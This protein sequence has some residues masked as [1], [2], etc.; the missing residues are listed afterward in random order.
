MSAITN[1]KNP[2]DTYVGGVRNA[3]RVCLLT[4]VLTIG[5]VAVTTMLGVLGSTYYPWALFGTIGGGGAMVTVALLTYYQRKSMIHH[6]PSLMW[7]LNKC[8][9][10]WETGKKFLA[11][12]SEKERRAFNNHLVQ[13]E[14]VTSGALQQTALFELSRLRESEE[15][16]EIPDLIHS[17]V[18]DFP[19]LVRLLNNLDKDWE[20]GRGVLRL[21]TDGERTE[22]FT[23][24]EKQTT[25]ASVHLQ[26]FLAIEAYNAQAD[27]EEPSIDVTTLFNK[28]P[29]L[30]EDEE[31]TT[32]MLNGLKTVTKVAAFYFE[33]KLHMLLIE[34]CG[35]IFDRYLDTM[36]KC[37]PEV[38][39]ALNEELLLIP[40]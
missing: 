28:L 30:E 3:R 29:A 13:Q 8:G 6:R 20:T 36:Q 19:T 14:K 23:F 34:S 25:A 21:M 31:A 1:Q 16:V 37:N 26:R 38:A 32:V 35:R 17:V 2:F 15:E 12:L 27:E 9:K 18:S 10:D 7:L 4:G 33:I 11:L 24:L 5:G 40:F 22:F 39:R